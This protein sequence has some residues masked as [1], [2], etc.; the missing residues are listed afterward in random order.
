MYQRNVGRLLVDRSRIKAFEPD[1]R[2]IP[3]TKKE[4]ITRV[5]CKYSY[6]CETLGKTK[7]L[8]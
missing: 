1:V 7:Y 8:N 5:K 3:N 2:T 4:V 6:E